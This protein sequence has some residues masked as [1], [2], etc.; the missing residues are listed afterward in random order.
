MIVVTA[1]GEDHE[2]PDG[3]RFSTEKHNL[4]IWG[5]RD[6]VQLVA[7]FADGQWEQVRNDGERVD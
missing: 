3:V 7:V 2:F 1:V 6:A 4:C 5:G